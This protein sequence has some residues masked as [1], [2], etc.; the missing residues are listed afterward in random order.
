VAL[1]VAVG[2]VV[3]A[4]VG[5]A[6][7]VAV[8]RGVA[9][10]CQ[11]G[12]VQYQLAAG[13]QCWT[14]RGSIGCCGRRC[15]IVGQGWR[16]WLSLAAASRYQLAAESCRPLINGC[17]ECVQLQTRYSSVF[18]CRSGF[19]G[20]GGLRVAVSLAVAVHLQLAARW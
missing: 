17:G 16:Y 7:V 1:L 11:G 2:G 20:H 4:S 13:L 9:V 5:N 10:G 12:V 15:R 18:G 3:A 8:G 19:G 6:V 14:R